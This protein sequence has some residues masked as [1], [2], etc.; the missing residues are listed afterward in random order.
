MSFSIPSASMILGSISLV[1]LSLCYFKKIGRLALWKDVL[2]FLLQFTE[3]QENNGT[4]SFY[5]PHAVLSLK[6]LFMEL[7][8]LGLYLT[9]S[10]LVEG[11]LGNKSI[12]SAIKIFN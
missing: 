10:L 11:L 3:T 6:Y 1:E 9:V 8:I 2:I 4:E 5:R 7:F 12:G